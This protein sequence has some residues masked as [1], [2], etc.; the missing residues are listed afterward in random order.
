MFCMRLGRE[1]FVMWQV[2]NFVFG[3]TWFIWPFVF[4]FSLAWGIVDWIKDECCST[5]PLLLA[6]LSL[7]IMLA[8]ILSMF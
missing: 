2:I 6:G 8:G 1:Y 3:W 4:V 5:K 7:T